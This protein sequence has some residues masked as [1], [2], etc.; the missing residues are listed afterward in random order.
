MSKSDKN[1]S[2][3]G[4]CERSAAIQ[5][6][7]QKTFDEIIWIAT[8]LRSSQW[9]PFWFRLVRLRELEIT[10]IPFIEIAGRVGTLLC[11][12][13]FLYLAPRGQTMKLFA[14]PTK[15]MRL[16]GNE[17]PGQSH[18]WYVC[19]FLLP[20]HDNPVPSHYLTTNGFKDCHFNFVVMLRVPE[21]R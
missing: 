15:N 16:M 18:Y 2:R 1:V 4:H 21:S 5:P 13:G 14:H 9:L 8:S 17:H 7:K 10:E 11:P 19:N 3:S 12:R 6:F 20:K